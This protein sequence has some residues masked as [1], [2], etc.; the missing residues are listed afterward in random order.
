MELCERLVA[1]DTRGNRTLVGGQASMGSEKLWDL[2]SRTK[3][4]DSIYWWTR[5]TFG[6]MRGI[7]RPYCCHQLL[8]ERPNLLPLTL[9]FSVFERVLV[10][11]PQVRQIGR[12]FTIPIR[13]FAQCMEH[14][15]FLGGNAKIASNIPYLFRM[16]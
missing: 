8:Y 5:G 4:E 9:S 14:S 12:I 2:F 1:T 13:K 7:F 3:P 10:R 16:N 15:K 6:S 11:N